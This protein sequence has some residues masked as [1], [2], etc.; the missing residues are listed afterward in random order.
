MSDIL[1]FAALA[2]VIAVPVLFAITVH[3]AAHGWV[4]SKCGDSTALSLGRV[5]FNP[6]KHIDPIGTVLVPATI[7]ITTKSL[8]GVPFLFGWAKPVPVDWRRLRNPRWD[9][10]LVAAAGPGVNLMMALAWGLAVKIMALIILVVPIPASALYLFAEMCVIGILINLFLMALNLFPLLPLDGGRILNALLPPAIA[11]NVAR[12]EPFGL[13]ILLALLF[14]PDGHPPGL[15]GA[16]LQ[17]VVS[18]VLDFI[19]A[20]GLVRDRFPI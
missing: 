13:V 20:S 3:E 2:L 17:P 18:T 9:M 8:V 6:L 15:L 16:V 11:E 4:A 7:Y 19:P 10:A 5:T 1:Q 14:L 12:L